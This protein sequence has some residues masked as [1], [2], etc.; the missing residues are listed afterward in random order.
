MNFTTPFQL[1]AKNAGG[2]V[3]ATFSPGQFVGTLIGLP[4]PDPVYL[5][6]E[7]VNLAL[8]PWMM[9]WRRAFTVSF[10]ATSRDIPGTP[11][12][13]GTVLNA[14]GGAG[15]SLEYSINGGTAWIPC[16]LAGTV[17][18]EKQDDKNMAVRMELSIQDK[19]LTASVF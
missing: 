16:F 11:Y 7:T 2:T 17:L 10:I 9:G 15:A 1:R 14:A 4:S 5:E 3:V 12:S 6:R 13:L 19:A 18:H 8:D